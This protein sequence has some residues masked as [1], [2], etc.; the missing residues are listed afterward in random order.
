MVKFA[1]ALMAVLGAFAV[2]AQDGTYFSTVYN[3]PY[4]YSLATHW[5][6]GIMAKDGGIATI[7]PN[8]S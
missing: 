1:S 4:K 6:G 2:H 8:G 7:H 3:D 5:N